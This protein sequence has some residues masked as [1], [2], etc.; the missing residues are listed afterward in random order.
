M[1]PKQAYDAFCGELVKNFDKD[2]DKVGKKLDFGFSYLEHIPVSA[3]KDMARIAV[4]EWDRWPSNFVKSTKNLYELWRKNSASSETNKPATK[5]EYCNGNGHFTTIMPA[6]VQPGITVSYRFA[7]RCAACSN[8]FGKLGHDIPARYP[9]EVKS[10]GHTIELYPVPPALE[11][12]TNDQ[13]LDLAKLISMAGVRYN[14]Q[15]ARPDYQ[16]YND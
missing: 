9:L 12:G 3:W 1:T 15:I 8:W 14:P 2:W 10:L 11:T 4:Y 6:E 7:W 13:P 16:P 5:C